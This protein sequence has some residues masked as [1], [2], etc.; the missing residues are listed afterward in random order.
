[1]IPSGIFQIGD[2]T[3]EPGLP[4]AIKAGRQASALTAG[5]DNLSESH[6]KARSCTANGLCGPGPAERTTYFAAA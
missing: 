6:P 5:P 3:F 2:T 1:M 4:G